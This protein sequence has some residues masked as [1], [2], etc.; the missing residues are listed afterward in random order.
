[1]AIGK[2]PNNMRIGI[3]NSEITKW[4]TCFDPNLITVSVYNETCNFNRISCRFVTSLEDS[5]HI[6][7]VKL[8]LEKLFFDFFEL[9]L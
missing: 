4:D 8:L 9:I 7:K 2:T 6:K 3:V 1:M 5:D